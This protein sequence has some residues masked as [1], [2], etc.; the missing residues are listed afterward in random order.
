MSDRIAVM[1]KGQLRAAGRPGEPVRAPDD[2]LRRRLPGH[3]QPAPGHGRGRRRPATRRSASR[4]DT[5]VRVP[6]R[7]RRIG[8]RPSPSAS[9]PRR[10]ACARRPTSVPD[11][12]N[13]LTGVVRD[14]S[15]LG[16]S[17]QY[18]VEARGG[19]RLTVYEQNVE[20][21]TRSELWAPGEEVR[22]TWSP[23]HSFA[24]VER[25][26][27]TGGARP[28]ARPGRR[29]RRADQHQRDRRG[30]SMTDHQTRLAGPDAT[31]LPAGH[32]P[33]RRRRVPGRL[34]RRRRRIGRAVGR[35]RAA[36]ATGDDRRPVRSSSPTGTPTST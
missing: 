31:P 14:A 28:H 7:P 20:R 15:Y 21:A 35:R 24:V 16:V 17:T 34:Q 25:R 13:R 26:R 5:I 32:R 10:S 6:Q 27:P 29:R 33:D 3:Q 2:A 36:P 18:L 11:G 1:N 12:H 8:R 4:D 19:A 23:D 22:L 30:D 9:G